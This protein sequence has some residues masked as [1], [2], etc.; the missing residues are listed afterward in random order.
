MVMFEPLPLNDATVHALLSSGAERTGLDFKMTCDLDERQAT[1]EIVK[2]IA[3]FAVYGGYIVIGADDRGSPSGQLSAKQAAL[4]DE[5]R[6]RPKIERYVHG[7]P[8]RSQSFQI[9]GKWIAVVCVLPHPDGWAVFNQDGSYEDAN[10]KRK[11]VFR[12]GEVF[13][14]HGSSSE[15]WTQQDAHAIRTE[16]R[17]QETERARQEL[18]DEF[19]HLLARGT[20]AQAAARGPV[21]TFTWDLDLE[22]LTGAIIEQLRSDDLIPLRL[23]LNG[24][25]ARVIDE[26]SAEDG[27]VDDLLDRL[28]SLAGTFSVLDRDAEVREVIDAFSSIYDALTV[29]YAVDRS[30]LRVAPNALRF[31]LITRMYALGALLLRRE[32]WPLVRYIAAIR[33]NGVAD[34]DWYWSNWLVHADVMAA[35]AGL[36]S[37]DVQGQDVYRGTLLYAQEHIAAV[38]ALHPDLPIDD[39]RIV[40]SLCQFSLL[41]CLVA[42]DTRY[43]KNPDP[44][45][46]QFGTFYSTRTDPILVRVLKDRVLRDVV[47]PQDDGRLAE[48]MRLIA[49]NASHMA[50]GFDGWNGY[51]A[52]EILEFLEH[53][54]DG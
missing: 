36:H 19:A 15:R 40:T 44:F 51:R 1:V 48:A 12:I 30:D 7:I 47:F 24:A 26:A 22:T 6:L 49:Y 46:A 16:I 37:R 18:R 4:F 14:R 33:P 5:A 41:A 3:A 23:L 32:Q 43:E 52:T 8:L 54:P 20:A 9:D 11:T 10:H 39:D 29:P 34:G 25:P 31:R 28:V 21:S 38:P 45:L 42:I 53:H 2:D 35:R 17:R 27:G 13:S 50:R